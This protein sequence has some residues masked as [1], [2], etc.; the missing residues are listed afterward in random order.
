[1]ARVPQRSQLRNLI[2]S[3]CDAFLKVRCKEFVNGKLRIPDR[4]EARQQGVGEHGVR[5][6]P[7]TIGDGLVS[8]A[9]VSAPE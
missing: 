7:A 3:P 1:M 5:T 9:L 2:R 4:F 8:G 6:C